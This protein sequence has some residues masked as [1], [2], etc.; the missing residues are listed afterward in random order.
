MGDP[1]DAPRRATPPL[2]EIEPVAS[3]LLLI[4]KNPSKMLY[5]GNSS[6]LIMICEKSLSSILVQEATNRPDFVL[7]HY[8]NNIY[9]SL[10]SK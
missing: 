7:M 5:R 3:G 2:I 6:I 4:A 1:G 8:N 9:S 10:L